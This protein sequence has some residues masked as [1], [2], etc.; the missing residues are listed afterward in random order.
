[1]FGLTWVVALAT[2]RRGQLAATAAGVAVAVALLASIGG[3]VSASKATM[4]RRAVAGVAVDWQVE[5]QTGADPAAV[6]QVVRA[7][8]GVSQAL[9]V[10]YAASTGL[11][12]TTAGTTQTTGPGVV[13][14]LPDTYRASFPDELRDLAGAGIGVLLAQQTAA[15]LHAAPGDVVTVGR[16]GLGPVAVRVDGVVDLPQADSLFQ[17]VGTPP[18]AQPQAPPDNVLLLPDA[19]WHELFDPL[20]AARPDL[21]HT[22]VHTRL[23]RALPGDPAAAYN[24]V[25]ARARNLEVRL[26]GTGLVG[27][28]LAAT[29]AAARAD[30]LYAQVLFLFL[31]LPGAALAGLLTASVAAAGAGRRRRE[32][33]LLRA[34]GA[35]T[36]RLVRLGFLEAG[37]AGLAGAAAGLGLAVA[38]SRVA[39]GATGFGATPLAGLGWVGGAALVGLAIAVATVAFPAWRNA[40]SGTVVADRVQ[41]GRAR[42]PR[43]AQ[44]G[45]DFWFLG[46]SAVVFW[47]TSRSG[48]QLVLAPEGVPAISVSYWAFA[49]PALLWAGTGLIAGRMADLMLGPGRRLIAGAVRPLAGPLAETVTASLARQRRLIGRAVVLVGLTASFAASTAT[50]NATYRQQ[51][52]VDARLSNGADVTVTESPGTV[53]GPRAAADLARIPGVA[54]V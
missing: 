27:D 12:A 15:N 44:A 22:Q 26:A 23:R 54:A 52:E 1:M 41:V 46:A 5:A 35:T 13:L 32:H 28:N 42:T 2:R 36:G 47:V 19:R 31:G 30:A 29:L 43:W 37:A 24:A 4:T 20:A 21:V 3:F 45:L 14:G 10:G 34:R 51:A 53:V 38:V 16:A 40:R 7:F 6:T 18:G 17:K 50:F 48:Y 33:A 11:E 39:F 9:P 49:G 25:S 8:P